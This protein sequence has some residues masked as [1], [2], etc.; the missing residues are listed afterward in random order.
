MMSS[1]R[2]YGGVVVDPGAAQKKK[3][4]TRAG[5]ALRRLS[6][7]RRQDGAP[8]SEC[9]IQQGFIAFRRCLVKLFP[10]ARSQKRCLQ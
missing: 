4:V 10:G 6:V 8:V 2:T 7:S 5:S 9:E 3:N 1:L